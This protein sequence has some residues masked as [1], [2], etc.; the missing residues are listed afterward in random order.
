VPSPSLPLT[1]PATRRNREPRAAAAAAVPSEVEPQIPGPRRAGLPHW[2]RGARVQA[3]RGARQ[4]AGGYSRRAS[5][6]SASATRRLR[7]DPGWL[8]LDRSLDACVRR[9]RPHATSRSAGRLQSTNLCFGVP[10]LNRR[11][12][13][14]K[15]P[16]GVL[17]AGTS[18]REPHRIS[19]Q[20]QQAAGRRAQLQQP[21]SQ[22]CRGPAGQA[23]AAGRAAGPGQRTAHPDRVCR[24]G[25]RECRLY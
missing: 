22:P 20:E 3:M 11:S 25:S 17:P 7:W 4:V 10:P 18:V 2:L 12:R 5:P 16:V 8:L 6:D 9:L 23:R 21:L 15:I 13:Q 24:G 19:E 14:Q 1:S